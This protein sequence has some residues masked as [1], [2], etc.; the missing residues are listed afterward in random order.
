MALGKKTGGRVKGTPNKLSAMVATRLEELGCDP[1]EGMA[2]IAMDENSPDELKG[3]MF[4]ELAQY[5]YPKRKAIEHTGAGGSAIEMNVTGTE[6]L[7]SR[8][9]SLAARIST[10]SDPVKPD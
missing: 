4:A 5:V 10:P 3:R 2:L 8:I 9:N 6:V 1:I 7:T